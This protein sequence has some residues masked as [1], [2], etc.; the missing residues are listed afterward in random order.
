[1]VYLLVPVAAGREFRPLRRG[2]AARLRNRAR[3]A[4]DL[5][6]WRAGIAPKLHF[7]SWQDAEH[8][9]RGDSAIRL[10]SEQLL[11]AAFDDAARIETIGWDDMASLDTARVNAEACLFVLGGGGYF[12]VHAGGRLAPRLARDLAVLEKLRCPI[13]AFAPGVNRALEDLDATALDPAARAV[14]AG[15]LGRLALCSVRDENSRRLL[16]QVAPGRAMVL[17]DPA[18][19]LAPAPGLAPVPEAPRE[20]VLTVGLNLAFHGADAS[21]ALPARLRL[22]AAAAR[23][24]AARR[25]CRFVY[26]VHEQPERLLP[27]LL[28]LEGVQAR[29]VDAAPA[30]ML[31]EYR[32][33]DLQVCQM[34]HSSIFAMA[35]GVPAVA[36]AYDVK[37]AGFF[38]L[39]GLSGFCLDGVG[40]DGATT[41]LDAAGA[42][43]RLDAAIAAALAQRPALVRRIAA[44][45]AALRAETEAFLA[46]A[47][48]LARF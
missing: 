17:A 40:V 38:E 7:S 5:A 32:T 29:V 10:A 11:R 23:R 27:R 14:L 1:V 48:R 35:A 34:L 31:A 24:L 3:R 15:L 28:R 47:T 9:N 41:R 2:P 44:R 18:L 36:L 13:V 33:L 46:A 22:V 21:A 12:A 37:N 39:M 45:T 43:A 30:A 8:T 6:Q 16:D 20:A 25:P 26:F 19:F 42:A 4:L